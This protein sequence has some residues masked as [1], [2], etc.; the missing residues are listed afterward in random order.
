MAAIC[1][2]VKLPSREG[3][4]DE[5]GI[6]SADCADR[7]FKTAGDIGTFGGGVGGTGEE[8]F[9]KAV[10]AAH[11]LSAFGMIRDGSEL[12]LALNPVERRFDAVD[13]RVLDVRTS[14]PGLPLPL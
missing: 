14:D 13:L 2:D 10:M 9:L 5:D 12:R 3:G 8:S 11:W 1:S 4:V 6:S 7:Y